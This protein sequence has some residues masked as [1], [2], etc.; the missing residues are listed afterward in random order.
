MAAAAQVLLLLLCGV[1]GVVKAQWVYWKDQQQGMCIQMSG[2][3]TVNVTKDKDLVESFKE[4]QIEADSSCDFVS[5]HY[6][7]GKPLH[8]QLV[9]LSF[10]DNYEA[11]LNFSFSGVC[12][13]GSQ[14]WS[15]EKINVM[16]FLNNTFISG[17]TAADVEFSTQYTRSYACN[18]QASYTFG[19]SNNT[20]FNVTITTSEWQFQA[21]QFRNPNANGTF[22]SAQEC[23]KD[24][25][26]TVIVPVVVG[27]ALGVLVLGVVLAYVV[28]YIYRR[29][30][31][32]S[33]SA[34]N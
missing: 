18:A 28:S 32:G 1:T 19:Q 21:F 4:W 16:M 23:Q 8:A 12:T 5:C 26:G 3:L 17:D 2:D 13:K 22:D 9:L 6:S 25:K 10:T 7:N 34:L 31:A 33:Y 15:L 20:A 27:A 29:R 14:S 30:K 11:A 24:S